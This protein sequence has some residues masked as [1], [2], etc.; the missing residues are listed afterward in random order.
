MRD[1]VVCATGPVP[2]DVAAAA[3]EIGV[4]FVTLGS[5]EPD[6]VALQLAEHRPHGYLFNWPELGAFLSGEL[7]DAAG[8]LRI[9]TY[10]GQS[11]EP[12]FYT[13]QMD[14]AALRERGILVTTTPGAE[15]A[16]AEAALAFLLAFELDLAP[17]NAARK[18][19]PDATVTGTRRR[20][21]VG[22][23]LGIVGMG[24]IGR[25]VAEL[26]AALRM[27]V[28]Y[29]SRTRRPSVERELGATFQPLHELFAACHHVS[30][31]LPSGPGEGAIDGEVLSHADGVTL[32]NT[33]SVATIVEPEALLKAL[34]E[35]RVA[36]FALEGR[37]PEPHDAEL[38]AYGD[39]RVLLLPPYTSYD[40]PHAEQLS[41]ERYLE[42]LAVLLDGGDVPHQLRSETG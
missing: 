17:T 4:E 1:F 8:G 9:V 5:L 3:A 14:V 28:R 26:A 33:T 31:H 42:S 18:A 41:W 27:D 37:Y 11:L 38:R 23:R 29:F 21:L 34:E 22:A 6:A 30:L 12:A 16:V 35:G 40:T 13:E 25:R 32:I 24:R 7:A 20:G 15:F 19:D 10:R 39:E 2:D 36:R